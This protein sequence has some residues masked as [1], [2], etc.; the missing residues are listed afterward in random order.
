MSAEEIDQATFAQYLAREKTIFADLQREVTEALPEE[1]KTP[2][3][4]FYR[5]S[6]V[7][8]GSFSR[9]GTVLLCCCRWAAARQRGAPP[10]PDRFALQRAL[11]GATLAGSGVMWAVA[12]RLP[13]H[14]T[15][16]GALM[17]VDWETWLAATRLA[18]REATRLAGADVPLHLVGYSNGGALALKYALD[19]LEDSHLRQPQQIILLSPMIGV[20]AFARFAGLAGY[21][22]SS[23]R[24]PARADECA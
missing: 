24:S 2:V 11:S 9:T 5:H 1:D 8:P 20:T 14:G 15:A 22:P 13:G 21:R 4:R 6:R 19:S 12:P 16:P 23:R 7:W 18:V 17:A 3:N 10:W